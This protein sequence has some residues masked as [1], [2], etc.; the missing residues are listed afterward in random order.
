MASARLVVL[1]LLVAGCQSWKLPLVNQGRRAQFYTQ[2]SDGAYKYGF[3]SAEGLFQVQEGSPANEVRGEF[4]ADG[5]KTEYTAGVDGFV[6]TSLKKPTAGAATRTY[7]QA[8]TNAAAV[9]FATLEELSTPPK[10]VADT[11]EVAAA[12]KAFEA[13][14]DA[15]AAAAEAAPDTDIIT[16][17][18]PV[19]KAAAPAGYSY[20]TPALRATYLAPAV[21]VVPAGPVVTLDAEGRVEDTAAVKAAK[22]AFQAAYDAAAAAADAAPD[23][24][25]ITASVEQ[26]SG[27]YIAPAV[28]RVQTS[29][30]V[31]P[32][33]TYVQS[34]KPVEVAHVRASQSEDGSY[35]FSY[36]TSDSSRHESADS[37]N[38]VQGN[39]EFVADDAQRRRVDYKAG[40]ETGFIATGA[41][42]PVSVKDTAD[43]AA[44]KA[45]FKSAFE[46]A[47][48]AAEAAADDPITY[49]APVVVPVSQT[50]LAPAPQAVVTTT[51]TASQPAEIAD[52]RSTSNTD[53]SYEFSYSTSDSAR[54]ESADSANNVQGN[55][56]FVA[57]DAQRR[58]VDYKAG[59]E[60]GF[61][62]SGA[63]LPVSVKDTADVAAAKASFKSAFESA[64]AAAAAAPD[65]SAIYVAP[66]VYSAPAPAAVI[67]PQPVTVVRYATLEELS[68]PPKPVADTAEV[69]AAKQ[70]FK[71]AYDAAAAAAEAAPDTDIITGPAPV[72]K[73]AAPAGYS[74]SAPALRTTYLAPAVSVV[75]AG[76]VVTLDAEGR[77]EDT[78]AV[79]AAK[80]AFQAAYDAAAAAAAAAPD[81]DIITA[82]VAPVKVYTASSGAT[83]QTKAAHHGDTLTYSFDGITVMQADG[84]SS[85]AK[86]GY[87]YEGK[88][89][90]TTS[91][92]ARRRAARY[93]NG[94]GRTSASHTSHTMA[95][96]RLVVLAL[97][98]AGCQSWKLPL[99]NQG[100]RAQFYT[101]Q[102]DGAYKY[103]FD[104]AEGLFQV[105]EGSPANEVRGEFGADGGKTEY[106]A[107]VG[108]FVVTSHK[109]PTGGAA[110][111]TYTQAHTN[112]AAVRFATLEELNTAPKP[113]ADTAEV[114]AAKQAFKIAYD[115]AA[116]AAEAA[117]DTDIITGPAPVVKAAAPDG[118][119]YSAPAL[120]TTY[121][122]PAVSVVPAG[123]VVTLDAEGRVE[124]TAEVK[125]AK[126]AFQAAYD[127]AA[128]AAD[129]APDTNIITASVEQPSGLYIAPA[130]TRVQ[131]SQPV[132][133]AATYVQSS[134]PVEVAHVRAS[135]SEDGSYQFSYETSDSA[136]HESADSANNVQGNF[137]FVADDAQRRR[138]DYKAGA[139]TGF[140]ATGAHLPVPVK[141]TAEVVAAKASFKSAFESAA[142]AA[143]AAADDPITYSA[144]VVVPVSQ[145]YLA[146]A[147]QAVVTTT[148][149][150]SQP[151]EIADFRSTSSTD[152]SYEFSYSTSDSARHESADSAN[153]VQGNFEFVADDAQR[154]RVDY[155]AGAETG[156]IATGAHLPVSVK[157]T[158]D[159]AAAKASFKS[160]FESAAAAA[161]AAPDNAVYFAPPVYSAPAPAAVI[162]PQPVTAVRYAT[163][164]ELSTPPKPVADTP[165][166][167]AA[168][169]AFEAAYDAAAAAAE[170]APDTDIITG[171]AP[172]V[173]AAAPAGY[174]YSA[175]ALRTT[176]LAPAVSVVPAGPVVTLDAEGRVEDTAEVKAAKQ[177]F[178]AAYDAAA[179][180]AAAAPDTDII[181]APVAPVKVYTTSSGATHQ[182]KAAHHGDTLTYSFDGITVMQADGASSP[183]KFGYTYE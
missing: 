4:G 183:A 59:A 41:H 68:T 43:V 2:Q 52:F 61:I 164:E 79:K 63:H 181:T 84:A 57:D 110:T 155:K 65:N 150:A 159:V 38:N 141:D 115:A 82:P 74:Y 100:R 167:A 91:R 105:Q 24:N 22:Q 20:N 128:A 170:A 27:L 36:E 16:G 37:A 123:P 13:A 5:G 182:T 162:A 116:A 153:N 75:P 174:S 34:T 71:I 6:V 10:P 120:R 156:F 30:L 48:A 122:A 144:P 21:S 86:F 95:S 160:A 102:S 176:Y 51:Y 108:G 67:A 54:H 119:S 161:A 76:P 25:I 33:A 19:V 7:T 98:V 23:T 134:K 109:K 55:F 154:R 138:V 111:R 114:A 103:G 72:V 107:G 163:L 106:T 124:D 42:L 89:S 46:S 26:P 99:V 81:T 140:I 28:T 104:S 166:V 169:K 171:P 90:T 157:D 172:V 168:K 3:D 40:A 14:Y 60:T 53:G 127:A 151:A 49:S 129:A 130:V 179:A 17:P 73:A 97:L 113:V 29:Q 137:E 77:V 70:A 50:Y 173:K 158:A 177:A 112:A 83:H 101:Q 143:E 165:E 88:H 47:A 44:A 92:G 131:T 126:Q 135:Q 8:H 56:E 78:A 145:T 31:Q 87:T 142:A 58:R 35:Q 180:A 32:A 118:Y 175:P 15:A 39:F 45:S 121:L 146:P 132:Q 139:D 64:A 11:A 133:P 80:Q 178:Q 147:P 66:P 125:A 12:K 9:R 96:A 149:T 136:R 1:A 62:A 85:P 148:Y 94:A 69:A 93:I 18:A 152:G 117:P